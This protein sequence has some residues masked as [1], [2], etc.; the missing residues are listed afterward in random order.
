MHVTSNATTIS[1]T[2]LGLR[3]FTRLAARIRESGLVLYGFG[4]RKTPKPFLASCNKFIYTEN[5]VYHEEVVPQADRAVLSRTD[6]LCSPAS[7]SSSQHDNWTSTPAPTDIP[8][9][10]I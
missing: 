2:R 8:S 10:A 1:G 5:L 7:A 9:S 4:E 6:G 3:D